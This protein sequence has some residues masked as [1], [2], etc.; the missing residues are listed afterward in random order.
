MSKTIKQRS[1]LALLRAISLAGGKTE[2]ANLIHVRYAHVHSWLR[3]DKQVPAHM[4]IP[5]EKAVNG[6]VSRYELRPDIY[7]IKEF[8][9]DRM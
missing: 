6:K 8:R 2:L 3:P 7:P 1:Q 4:C 9:P 5:I